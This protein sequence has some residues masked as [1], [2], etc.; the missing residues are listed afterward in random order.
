MEDQITDSI[1]FDCNSSYYENKKPVLLT[2]EQWR[3][4]EKKRLTNDISYHRKEDKEEMTRT[5]SR[6]D[7][8]KKLYE[9]LPEK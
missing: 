8:I 2:G 1:K 3:K 7:W 5:K 4:N 6:N 9:S